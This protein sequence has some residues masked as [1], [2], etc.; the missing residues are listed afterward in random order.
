MPAVVGDEAAV[1]APA[2]AAA[3]VIEIGAAGELPWV[4]GAEEAETDGAG[5]GA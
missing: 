1:G 5:L 3:G 2:R 4:A